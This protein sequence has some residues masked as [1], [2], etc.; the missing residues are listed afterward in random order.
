MN[1][2]AILE[3]EDLNLLQNQYSK[4][5]ILK[6]IK[7]ADFHPGFKFIVLPINCAWNSLMS[8]LEI[9]DC[10]RLSFAN[11]SNYGSEGYRLRV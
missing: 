6:T 1:L 7:G 5:L 4:V 2:G 8:K 11:L 9:F 3:A 10:R